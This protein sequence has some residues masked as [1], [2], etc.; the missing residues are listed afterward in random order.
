VTLGIYGSVLVTGMTLEQAKRAIELHLSQFLFDPEISLDV[1][2][3][4][5]KVYYVIIDLGGAGERV[6]RLPVFGNETVLDAIGEI[7]GLPGGTDRKR[8]W[9]ARQA[10]PGSACGVVLPVDWN[11]VACGGATATNYQIMPGD[12]A[13]VSVDPPAFFTCCCRPVWFAVSVPNS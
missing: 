3:Y 13:Y 5:S 12:R 4:N 2:G 9:I 8:I 11:A 10:G 1:A 6:I 7:K